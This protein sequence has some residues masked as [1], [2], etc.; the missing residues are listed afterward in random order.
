MLEAFQS[1]LLELVKLAAADL[2]AATAAGDA[3]CKQLLNT[4]T[5][6]AKLFYDLTAQVCAT[7]LPPCAAT[8]RCH[9]TLPPR[10]P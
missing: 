10:T 5:L 4:L 3:A 8:A 2:P 9:R 1:P 6:V 7:A